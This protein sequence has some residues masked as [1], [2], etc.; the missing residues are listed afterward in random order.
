MPALSDRSIP[1]SELQPQAGGGFVLPAGSKDQLVLAGLLT[2]TLRQAA[3]AASSPAEI[4][5][6]SIATDATGRAEGG[7]IA[8]SAQ[9]DRETRTLIFLSG[10][11]RENGAPRLRGTAIYRVLGR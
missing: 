10:D 1:L 2:H 6:V 4:E 8:F 9:I 11:A 5:L 7:E 3:E